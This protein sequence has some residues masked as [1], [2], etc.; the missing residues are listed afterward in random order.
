M[1]GALW[2]EGRTTASPSFPTSP[3]YDFA[4]KNRPQDIEKAKQ[5]LADAGYGPGKL[6]I[7]FK[8]T[9]NRSISCRVGGTMLEWFKE[10][11]INMKSSS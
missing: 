1:Q 2:G 5:L 4:L 6:N 7:V 11:G 9:T 10:A 8:A 3:S